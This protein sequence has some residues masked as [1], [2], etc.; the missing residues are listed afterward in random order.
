MDVP[1]CDVANLKQRRQNIRDWSDC[2]D[3]E[4]VRPP[5]DIST[6]CHRLEAGGE[7]VDSGNDSFG[8]FSGVEYL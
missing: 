5:V 7:D 1:K 6:F 4:A 3:M 2:S 8:D